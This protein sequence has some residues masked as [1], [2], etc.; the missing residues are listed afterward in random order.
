MNL[1]GAQGPAPQVTALHLSLFLPAF[2]LSTAPLANDPMPGDPVQ[3]S[4][5]VLE[6]LLPGGSFKNRKHVLG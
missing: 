4:G 3:T 5:E 1:S 2:L 6:T